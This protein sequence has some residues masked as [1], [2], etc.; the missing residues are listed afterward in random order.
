MKKRI[1]VDVT[2]SWTF[3]EKEWSDEQDHIR[4]VRSNPKLVLGYDIIHSIFCLN[5]MTT[6]DLKEITA[7]DAN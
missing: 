4:E 6:P 2:L 5:E 3:D 7:Y 1:T